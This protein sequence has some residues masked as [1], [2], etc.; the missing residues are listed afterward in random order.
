MDLALK[1][2]GSPA[3]AGTILLSRLLRA[4]AMFWSETGHERLRCAP[5]DKATSAYSLFGISRADLARLFDLQRVY[6]REMLAII[7]ASEPAEE[8]VLANMHLVQLTI[9]LPDVEPEAPLREAPR[10][11][12]A[13]KSCAVRNSGAPPC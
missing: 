5:P 2:L 8:L 12:P 13:G 1:Q 3:K 11:C 10:R 6:F 9:P 4:I 7:A